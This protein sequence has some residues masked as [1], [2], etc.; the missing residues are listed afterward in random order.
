MVLI[1]SI[2]WECNLVHYTTVFR[3][4]LA[5][6]LAHLILCALRTANKRL[7]LAKVEV[8]AVMSHESLYYKPVYARF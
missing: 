6:R 4:G 1:M 8:V 2:R 7:A 5:L 3:L